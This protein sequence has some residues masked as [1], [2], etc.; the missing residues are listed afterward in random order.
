MQKH[1]ACC[2]C[3]KGAQAKTGCSLRPSHCGENEPSSDTVI[4]VKFQVVLARADRC[5][6]GRRHGEAGTA[7][8]HRRQR[9]SRRATR[10]TSPT[11]HSRLNAGSG[12]GLW[13]VQAKPIYE[14]R[15]YAEVHGNV[16]SFRFVERE[17]DN[18]L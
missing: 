3:T 10:P 14:E 17:S 15:F 2:C 18:G 1:G 12:T 11:S 5:V 9:A 6:V 16:V 13:S 8:S 4:V 7:G